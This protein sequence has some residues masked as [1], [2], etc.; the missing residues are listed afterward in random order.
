MVY[1]KRRALATVSA[2]LIYL[3]TVQIVSAIKPPIGNAFMPVINPVVV[4]ALGV[5]VIAVAS[6]VSLLA[7][8][9]GRKVVTASSP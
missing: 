9:K 4:I 5:M 7:E 6:F 1:V 2:A 8:L 3:G